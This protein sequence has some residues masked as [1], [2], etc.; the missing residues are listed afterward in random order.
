MWFVVSLATSIR[1]VDTGSLHIR[2]YPTTLSENTPYLLFTISYTR[3]QELIAS[4]KNESTSLTALLTDVPTAHQMAYVAYMTFNLM[5]SFN[6]VP[7]LI[8]N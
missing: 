3:V 2:R 5:L 6:L 1:V 7:R 8:S 4:L